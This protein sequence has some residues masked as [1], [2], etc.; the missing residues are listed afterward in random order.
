MILT[1]TNKKSI[2]RGED[3]KRGGP[4]ERGRPRSKRPCERRGV[5]A[6]VCSKQA[7]GTKTSGKE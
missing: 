4:S 7:G 2:G 1:Y 5:C 3:K 6:T